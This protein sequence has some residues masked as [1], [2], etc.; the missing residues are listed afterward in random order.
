MLR[1]IDRKKSAMS[2]LGNKHIGRL[3]NADREI[4]NTLLRS[5]EAGSR[6]G[7]LIAKRSISRNSLDLSALPV[8]VWFPFSG[9]F[10]FMRLKAGV[11]TLVAKHLQ[12]EWIPIVHRER[13]VEWVSRSP[14]CVETPRGISTA[15]D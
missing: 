1:D 5:R 12:T 14:L 10:R 11:H 4:N 3:F 9:C 15:I 8:L 2:P 7:G 13:S 6:E